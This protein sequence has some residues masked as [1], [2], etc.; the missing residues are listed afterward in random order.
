M[1]LQGTMQEEAYAQVEKH[2]PPL[3]YLGMCRKSS[4]RIRGREKHSAVG[5]SN[6]CI[7]RLPG[8]LPDRRG[9]RDPGPPEGQ[10]KDTVPSRAVPASGAEMEARR[11]VRS[12]HSRG[13]T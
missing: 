12:L 13:H 10:A 4:S 11:C 8:S 3:G 2:T 7:A 1:L 5:P 9:G 6:D